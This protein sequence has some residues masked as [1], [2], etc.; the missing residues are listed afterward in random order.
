MLSVSKKKGK[1]KHT[2]QQQQDLP[3]PPSSQSSSEGALGSQDESGGGTVAAD[4]GGAEQGNS[5]TVKIL[6]N[7]KRYVFDP[8]KRM[9]Q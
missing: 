2:Q 9:I 1:A 4:V 6:L 3:P 7:F 8:N 5:G